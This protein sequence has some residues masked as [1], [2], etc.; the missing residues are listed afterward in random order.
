[1]GVIGL[2]VVSFEKQRVGR[3]DYGFHSYM[4][5]SQFVYGLLSQS[6][7]NRALPLLNLLDK[8]MDVSKIANF[9]K[10]STS[11]F[12]A[13]Y[14]LGDTLRDVKSVFVQRSAVRRRQLVHLRHFNSLVRVLERCKVVSDVEEKS[15][16]EAF[17]TFVV[18]IRARHVNDDQSAE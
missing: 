10:V 16:I 2:D 1:M 6:C 14:P 9:K 11:K 8:Y 5:L 12:E 13:I 17:L 3:S 18:D 4:G 7:K 15:A